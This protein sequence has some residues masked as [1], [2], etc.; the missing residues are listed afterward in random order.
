[1]PLLV[2]TALLALA[3]CGPSNSGQQQA[4]GTS[5]TAASTA[6]AK[7]GCPLTADEVSAALGIQLPRFNS[8]AGPGIICSFRSDATQL[9]SAPGVDVQTF[10]LSDQPVKTLGDLRARLASLNAGLT[11]EQKDAQIGQ[12]IDEPGWGTDAFQEITR[13]PANELA[14]KPYWMVEDWLPKYH[15]TI[16]IPDG[17]PGVNAAKSV[18]KA[19]G[20]KAA[21]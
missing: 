21:A 9:F 17:Y 19:V 14:P 1:L 2:G 6:A 13:H 12:V 7:D 4:A 15:I 5:P 16:V 20:D 3:A 11:A 10:P 8:P 18:G